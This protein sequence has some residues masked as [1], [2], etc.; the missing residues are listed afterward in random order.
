MLESLWIGV[1]VVEFVYNC[2]IL[3]IS[4]NDLE[5]KYVNVVHTYVFSLDHDNKKVM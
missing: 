2:F 1:L 3:L 5:L 4:V